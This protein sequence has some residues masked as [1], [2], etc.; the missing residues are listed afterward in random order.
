MHPSVTSFTH[1]CNQSFPFIQQKKTV[2]ILSVSI[3]ADPSCLNCDT[4][5][6]VGTK[7]YATARKNSSDL[8]YQRVVLIAELSDSHYRFHVTEPLEQ[9]S[10]GARTI[11]SVVCEMR[12]FVDVRLSRVNGPAAGVVDTRTE[13]QTCRTQRRPYQG[14][15]YVNPVVI[16]V[17][18]LDATAA[19]KWSNLPR[20]PIGVAPNRPPEQS[21]RADN[22]DAGTNDVTANADRVETE[23]ARPDRDIDEDNPVIYIDIPESSASS[24]VESPRNE[25]ASERSEVTAVQD[26]ALYD[27]FKDRTIEVRASVD[28][29]D[30]E[31]DASTP[32][33]RNRYLPPR[34]APPRTLHASQGTSSSVTT[35]PN[36][37]TTTNSNLPAFMSK[38]AGYYGRLPTPDDGFLLAPIPVTDFPEPPPAYTEV[39]RVNQPSVVPVTPPPRTEVVTTV[40]NPTSTV[41]PGP[42][43]KL[44]RC[45][46]CGQMVHS[47][48]VRESGAFTHILALIV[49]F[50][51]LIPVAIFIYCTDSCKYKNHYCPNCNQ[52]IGYEIPILCQQMAFV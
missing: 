3:S 26:T 38:E 11:S 45:Q 31:D 50:L 34:P 6:R 48:V 28:D 32:P 25:N 37:G 7:H 23:S 13:V 33:P 40:T 18:S 10:A 47:L 24:V 4:G 5:D 29:S 30:D 43:R 39:D 15:P 8:C 35:S 2:R 22:R 12:R 51:C 17:P 41:R 44:L 19:A 1:A 52:L 14:Y 46:H 20:K 27:P 49:A 16:D 36:S 9:S 21:N 42:D